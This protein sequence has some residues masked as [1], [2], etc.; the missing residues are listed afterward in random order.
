MAEVIVIGPLWAD[1]TGADVRRFASI[2]EFDQWRATSTHLPT[3]SAAVD[4]ALGDLGLPAPPAIL[5]GLFSWLRRQE[6]IPYTKT[7]ILQWSSRRSFYRAWKLMP[8]SAAA[9]LR[10]VQHHQSGI[11]AA[12]GHSTAKIRRIAR[13]PQ[14]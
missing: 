6:R 8:E 14:S 13:L 11:L 12:Q 4:A 5:D 2:A 7:L 10:R 9:F 1:L 3:I